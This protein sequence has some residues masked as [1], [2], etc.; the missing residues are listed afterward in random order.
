MANDATLNIQINVSRD[1]NVRFLRKWEIAAWHHDKDGK[2]TL[3]DRRRM[4]GGLW[5]KAR[6]KRKIKRIQLMQN[7]VIE[8]LADLQA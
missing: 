1:A 6:L 8:A 4:F 3:L 7:K 5:F 2:V